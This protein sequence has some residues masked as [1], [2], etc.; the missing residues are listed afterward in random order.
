MYIFVLKVLGNGEVLEFDTPSIL[1]SN[2]NSYFI[3]LVKQSGPAEAEYL[4]ILANRKN[5]EIIIDD[6][7]IPSVNET[8]PLLV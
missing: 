5:Q 6:E 7:L 8:D 3:S 4:R 1:L 2:E